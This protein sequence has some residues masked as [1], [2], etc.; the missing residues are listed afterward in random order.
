MKVNGN[1]IKEVVKANISIK[2]EIIMKG[3]GKVKN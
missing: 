2:M 1:L 3:I